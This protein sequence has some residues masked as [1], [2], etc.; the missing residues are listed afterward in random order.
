MQT[1]ERLTILV[2]SAAGA[3]TPEIKAA[4]SVAKVD[5]VGPYPADAI[6]SADVLRYTAAIID[7]RYEAEIMLRLTEQLDEKA[8]PHLFFVP[9]AVSSHEPGPFVLSGRS[10]DIQNIVSGL[11]AQGCS[12]RH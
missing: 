3:I 8:I 5:L 6:N 1:T 4:W 11:M 9:Q 2:V 10:Y 12:I 7:A